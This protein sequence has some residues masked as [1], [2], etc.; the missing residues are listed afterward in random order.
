MRLK[1][2]KIDFSCVEEDNTSTVGINFV[3]LLTDDLIVNASNSSYPLTNYTK[4][5]TMQNNMLFDTLKM[6]VLGF[7]LHMSKHMQ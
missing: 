3:N 1:D 2:T 6:S 7:I 4:I 5:F